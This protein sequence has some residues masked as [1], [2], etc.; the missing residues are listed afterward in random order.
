[1]N[2]AMQPFQL[3]PIFLD[4]VWGAAQMPPGLRKI[5][6]PPPHTGE[7]WL[8]SDRHHI[9]RAKGGP[10]DGLGLDEIV[11]QWPGQITGDPE[12]VFFPLLLKILSVGQWLSVQVH[13]NDEQARELE[14]E[15][16]GKSEAW[17]VLAAEPGAEIIHGLNHPLGAGAI[18]GAIEKGMMADLLARIPVVTG[19]TYAIPAGTIHATGPGL[20]ILE[21]QQASDVTYRIYDWDRP[22]S[23]GVLRPLHLDKALS[24]MNT[25]GPGQAEDPQVLEG[26]PN[27]SRRL[28][29]MEHFE[30]WHR[31]IDDQ[32][33]AGGDG[34]LRLWYVAD[35][36]G[37]LEL[38]GQKLADLAPG[39]CWVL[40]A[41]GQ[42]PMVVPGDDELDI[43]EGVSL[44]KG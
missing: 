23:D 31:R 42:P 21:I 16:W 18:K 35:G 25:S 37:S 34:L 29:A 8:A 32:Y 19:M 40:P 24:V 10:F 41:M 36:G 44:R 7:I 13:P 39:Q 38:G 26:Q 6:N 17:H 14:G 11:R 22:G 12:A 9:T 27:G 2:Q 4:K 5:F 3:E 20:T 43:M 1:M 33:Q 28:V 15:P 30:L